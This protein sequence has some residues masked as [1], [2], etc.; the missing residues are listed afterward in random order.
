MDKIDWEAVAAGTG[1]THTA[2]ECKK[3]MNALILQ[4]R[5]HRTLSE[6]LVDAKV[7]AI[8]PFRNKRTGRIIHPDMPK[9][10]MTPYFRFFQEKRP[11]YKAVNPDMTPNELSRFMASE[12]NNL[13]E[14][15]KAKYR[16]KYDEEMEEYRRKYAHFRLDHPELFKRKRAPPN[17]LAAQ[18]A[19]AGMPEKPQKPYTLY[20]AN[21]L[22]QPKYAG[23]DQ[24][25]AGEAIRAAWT[26]LS[27]EKRMKWIKKSIKDERRYEEELATFMAEHP[28]YHPPERAKASVLNKGEQK[29][30][31]KVEGR[32]ERPP[33]SGYILYS[34]LMMPKLEELPAKEKVVIIAK[35]WKELEEEERARYNAKAAKAQAKYIEAFDAYLQTLPEEEREKV[36]AEQKLKLPS[37]RR[38]ANNARK[39]SRAQVVNSA[40]TYY[41]TEEL[42]RMQREQPMRMKGE[43]IVD[44]NR[45]WAAMSNSERQEYINLAESIKD[46]LPAKGGGTGGVGAAPKK[47]R[48]KAEKNPK[49][50]EF[51]AAT[52]RKRPPKNG[53]TMYMRE[54]GHDEQWAALPPTQK[55]KQM[56]AVWKLQFSEEERQVYNDKCKQMHDEYTEMVKRFQEV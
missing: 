7:V 31:D 37:E 20:L 1:V 53:F 45:R 42:M 27:E 11:K 3:A 6:I 17:R 23:M 21:R 46:F 36:L 25:E 35:R 48:K 50:I 16:R 26:D 44:I 38:I 52:G 15:K 32:P 12:Y 47:T 30:K 5:T 19:A 41:Q 10:P 29:L 8:N 14:K 2:E 22:L 43:L 54:R 56:A 9:K 39:A 18:M 24:K 13:S 4:V 28:N 49:E 34:Q 51:M 40:L 55:M 33:H